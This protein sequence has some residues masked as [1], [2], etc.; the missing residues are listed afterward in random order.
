[1]TN[2]SFYFQGKAGKVILFGG[3]IY[4][5][6][7]RFT[8]K[9]M[10]SLGEAI[11]RRQEFIQFWRISTYLY[12][13]TRR[14]HAVT[15]PLQYRPG[16]RRT[17]CQKPITV[18]RSR[19]VNSNQQDAGDVDNTHGNYFE[20]SMSKSVT[21]GYNKPISNSQSRN[22]IR[23]RYTKWRRPTKTTC[24]QESSRLFSN[25]NRRFTALVS[26]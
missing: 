19:H 2:C 20:N 10:A 7:F 18:R 6:G 14:R 17:I 21:Q 13:I 3:A 26:L 16:S 24:P 9:G 11:G 5:G 25:D 12:R 8:S 22:I 4:H 1:M 15:V 23:Q